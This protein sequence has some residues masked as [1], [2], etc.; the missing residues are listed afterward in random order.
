MHFPSV[1]DPDK[2]VLLGLH[3][4]G[5]PETLYLNSA[6]RIVHVNRVP[7]TSTAQVKHDIATYLNVTS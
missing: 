6:G 5:P 2:K 4:P 1:S 3:F 7:Y